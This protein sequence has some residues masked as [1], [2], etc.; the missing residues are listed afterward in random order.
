M[1]GL[2]RA[3][4]ALPLPP[5]VTAYLGRVSQ[6]L[7]AD[8]PDGWVR[9][10]RPQAMHITLRFLG[11]STPQQLTTL[12]ARLIPL[13]QAQPGVTLRLAALGCFPNARRPRVIW[14]GVQGEVAPLEK[15]AGQIEAVVTAGGWTPEPR[16]FQAHI[17]LGRMRPERQ[18]PGVR[19]P[20]G[21]LLTPQTIPVDAIHLMRSDLRP[22]GP[23]YTLL[24]TFPLA[25]AGA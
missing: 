17:T 23:Q 14:A 25:P 16:S 8:W 5:A 20:A 24:H 15:L 11:E 19:L 13:V 2:I 18:P 10:V 21:Q 9:W 4:I 12:T 1:A 7:S 3:F 6:E 22:E